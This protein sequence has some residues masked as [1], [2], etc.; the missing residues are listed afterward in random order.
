MQAVYLEHMVDA[1]E[2]R[3]GDPTF[4]AYVKK[5]MD[6]AIAAGH[7]GDDVARLLDELAT[8]TR[9]SA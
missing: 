2:R 1:S 3:G 9:T 4:P 6:G 8:S 5:L 7:G